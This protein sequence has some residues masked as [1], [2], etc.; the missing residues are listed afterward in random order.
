MCVC[1]RACVCVCVRYAGMLWGPV[2]SLIVSFHLTQFPLHR[3]GLHPNPFL[4][5]RCSLTHLLWGTTH[6]VWDGTKVC[7]V[8]VCMYVCLK[9]A[10]CSLIVPSPLSPD[11][12]PPPPACDPFHPF[13]QRQMFADMSHVH[14]PHIVGQYQGVYVCVSCVYSIGHAFPQ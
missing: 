7:G 5:F 12:V 1:V 4:Q 13:L 8:C 10:T 3:D 9:C 6:T 2:C 11:S 14:Q